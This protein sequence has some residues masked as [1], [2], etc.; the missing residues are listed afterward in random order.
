M[1]KEFL[2]I[3]TSL[4]SGPILISLSISVPVLSSPS[5]SVNSGFGSAKDLAYFYETKSSFDNLSLFAYMLKSLGFGSKGIQSKSFVSYY[6]S[7]S[8]WKGIKK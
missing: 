6:Q 5:A 3:L 2:L 8:H 4:L 7:V 1:L